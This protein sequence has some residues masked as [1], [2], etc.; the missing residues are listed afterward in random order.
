M[1]HTSHYKITFV[2]AFLIQACLTKF[3]LTQNHLWIVRRSTGLTDAIHHMCSKLYEPE[4]FPTSITHFSVLLTV[5][6]TPLL[7]K[8]IK[9]F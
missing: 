4:A 2:Y 5:D 1:T 8:D 6:L 9:P 7:A 3:Y